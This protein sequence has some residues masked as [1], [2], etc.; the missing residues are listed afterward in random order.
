MREYINWHCY[1]FSS[2]YFYIIC[3]NIIKLFENVKL[4]NIFG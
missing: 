1:K 3:E 4:W 2:Y